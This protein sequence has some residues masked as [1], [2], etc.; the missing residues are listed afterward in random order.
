MPDPNTTQV[1]A[2]QPPIVRRG[3]EA[4]GTFSATCLRGV[5]TEFQATSYPLSN[6]ANIYYPGY[7]RGSSAGDGFVAF[8]EPPPGTY[9]VYRKI[10]RYPTI[11]MPLAIIE[12]RTEINEWTWRARDEDQ[13]ESRVE[14][15]QRWFDPRRQKIVHDGMMALRYGFSP[16]EKMWSLV[17]PKDL[18]VEGI[19]GK[20]MLPDLKP[21]RVDYTTFRASSDYKRIIG[22]RNRPPYAQK[23]T[24]LN[25][26]KC[27][28][29][30]FGGEAGDPYGESLFENVREWWSEALQVRAKISKY[31]NKISGVIGQ[32]HY[33]EGVSKN[34]D[35][36]DTPNYVLAQQLAAAASEG[37]WLVMQN[38]FASFIVDPQNVKP[39]DLDKA[40]AAAGKAEWVVSFLDPGGT[41]HAPGFKE[42]LQYYDVLM[43]RGILQ[44]ERSMLESQKSGS[45]ADSQMHGQQGAVFPEA[46]I[47]KFVLNFNKGVTDNIIQVN[48]WG[49]PGC[50]Y[51]DPDPIADDEFDAKLKVFHAAMQSPDVGPGL[52]QRVDVDQLMDDLSIP[53][54]DDERGSDFDIFG[55]IIPEMEKIKSQVGRNGNGPRT[56]PVGRALGVR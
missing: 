53:I 25:L 31:I 48:G 28:W 37:K 2:A 13:A 3:A 12:S 16:W 45:R 8:N 43:V 22:L 30:T 52:M 19:E 36:T 14:L 24:D 54:K 51:A 39:A 26:D 55:D 7:G 32:I 10:A 11:A 42:L 29:F 21:L 41:D 56:A 5:V 4:W 50:L 35:G 46:L 1:T 44:P 17:D 38:R 9:E 20:V 49:A 23:D 40:L 6:P 47:T 33:P 18:G 34:A 15:L 27:F